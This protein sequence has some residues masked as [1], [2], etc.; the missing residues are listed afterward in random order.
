LHERFGDN[1][2]AGAGVI[3]AGSMPREAACR[4]ADL[5]G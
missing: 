5:R 2:L 1:A 4:I 3:L